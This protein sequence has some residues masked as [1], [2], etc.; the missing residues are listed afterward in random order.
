MWRRPYTAGGDHL[1]WSRPY[2]RA[3][4]SRG[5]SP[6]FH[7]CLR[8]CPAALCSTTLSRRGSV[9]ARHLRPP[10]HPR[11]PP[12]R[13]SAR[14]PHHQGPQLLLHSPVSASTSTTPPQ[15]TSAPTPTPTSPA[16]LAPHRCSP[17]L[18]RHHRREPRSG[19]PPPC[20]MPQ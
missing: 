16:S 12:S 14:R 2:L 20:P 10:L 8:A 6:S 11:A 18:D 5:R 13:R 15:S 4:L 1:M 19:E 9:G 7:L 17:T 3:R